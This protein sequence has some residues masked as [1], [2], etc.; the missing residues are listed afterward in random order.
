MIERN[1]KKVDKPYE[2]VAVYLGGPRALDLKGVLHSRKYDPRYRITMYAFVTEEDMHQAQLANPALVT[3][4][5][6][7]DWV[8]DECKRSPGA[9]QTL[10]TLSS[11]N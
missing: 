8:D 4:M 10:T 11:S 2:F 6:N 3:P 7:K 9:K 5:L 1:E